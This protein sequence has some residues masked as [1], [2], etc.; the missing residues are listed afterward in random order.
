LLFRSVEVEN[1][2]SFDKASFIFED[3]LILVEGKN[4][5][6]KSSLF[7]DSICYCL[8]GVTTKGTKADDVVNWSRNEDCKVSLV[9]E[10]NDCVY[11]VDRYRAHS[12]V[13]SKG[14]QYGNRLLY[15]RGDEPVESSSVSAT[16][17]ALLEEVNVDIEL[18]KC[19]LLLS[20]D[21]KFNFVDSTDK[22]QKEILSKIRRVD[23]DELLLRSKSGFGKIESGL[24]DL[25]R[26]EGVLLSH[27]ISSDRLKGLRDLAEGFEA[28]TTREVERLL[29]EKK[30]IGRRLRLEEGKPVVMAGIEVDVES[31][32][33]SERELIGE[34]QNKLS[35]LD[36]MI[37]AVNKEIRSI[38]DVG[39]VCDVCCQPVGCEH[40]EGVL[41]KKTKRRDAL[42]LKW[43]EL[44]DQAAKHRARL[45]E[46]IEEK[47]Q[48]L[49]AVKESESRVRAIKSD[50]EAM[51]RL[52]DQMC[53]AKKRENVYLRQYSE[54][55]EKQKSIKAKL[56]EIEER[57]AE[58]EADLP[59]Y[60]FWQRAFGDKGIKSFIFDSICG[61]LTTKANRFI[62]FLTNGSISISFDTQS[63]L[64]DGSLREK[65]ECCITKDGRK[66][67]YHRY[68]GGEKR[69]V[70]LA[71]DMALSEIMSEFYGTKF[72]LLVLDE[73][74]NYID[75]DGK[76]EYFNLAKEMS[77]EKCV[78]IIDHDSLLKT[79]F[80]RVI[81]VINDSGVSAIG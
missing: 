54:E 1:F 25:V 50:K 45:A 77:R 74:S 69:R 61:T 23:F 75:V 58:L 5:S 60:A 12:G 47:R 29:S 39:E 33:G 38:E 70:S 65:F 42:V 57:R 2:L 68:S 21:S 15:Y 10:Y 26:K 3:G 16:Q 56:K 34:C 67:S 17:D 62:N 80:D 64:K 49:S 46:L 81:T 30:A 28:E 48:I 59:Y 32:I 72:N 37:N 35:K 36:V 41:S 14:V 79:K 31:D 63:E 13:D 71:V 43:K 4:G 7:V 24:E 6:G 78:I 66:V 51:V 11:R 52:D 40:V 18:L 55:V 53:A 9:F 8:T 19:T 27:V 44:N 76:T 73:Q 22:K 20:Q